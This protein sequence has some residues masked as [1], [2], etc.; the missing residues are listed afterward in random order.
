MQ[1]LLDFLYDVQR[2]IHDTFAERIAG[3]SAT[4]DWAA[5]LAILPLGAVFGLVH[6]MTPGH[7][8]SVLAAYIVG[9]NDS[10]WRALATAAVLA[11]TH[12]GSAV[13]LAVTASALVTRTIVG[14]GQAPML[15]LISRSL[16]VLIGVWLIVRALI[17]RPHVH[18]EGLAVGFVAGLVPCPL[19]LFVMFYALSRSV[20]EAGLVFALAMLV[21][22][23]L[24]LSG[25]AL[26]AVL[27]R[28]LVV[29]HAHLVGPISR[30]VEVL[31]GVMLLAIAVGELV[32]R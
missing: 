7:S 32:G 15:D 14:V 3:F 23:E 18:G 10:R 8:K 28:D 16:L 24:V 31:A 19:T 22:V 13:V 27:A 12:I 26:L 6:A 25:V 17:K 30:V 1:Q 29:R 20:P 2:A 11:L 4:H 5:L 9:S 21:G